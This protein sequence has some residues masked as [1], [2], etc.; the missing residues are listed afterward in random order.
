MVRNL[1]RSFKSLVDDATWMDSTTKSI[2]KDKVD[3]MVEF[4]GYPPWITNKTAL[5][6][7]YDGVIRR[8]YFVALN[9]L[10]FFLLII[11]VTDHY[12]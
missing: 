8:N 3:A 1:K 2:A 12:F 4:I 5:E 7:Y 9:I 11:I 6:D 10:P